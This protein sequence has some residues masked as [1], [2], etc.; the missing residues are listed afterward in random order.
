MQIIE[1]SDRITEP[2]IP[3][4][5]AG[6]MP[7]LPAASFYLDA[8]DNELA[9]ADDTATINA[10]LDRRIEVMEKARNERGGEPA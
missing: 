8:I 4:W 6:E 10:L 9:R 3:A 1:Y 2:D 5:P 7:P